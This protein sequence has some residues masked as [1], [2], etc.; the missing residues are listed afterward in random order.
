YRR[1]A[2]SWSKSR[3]WAA[4]T[5]AT[6]ASPQASCSTNCSTSAA[7]SDERRTPPQNRAQ[8]VA[9]LHLPLSRSV[10]EGAGGC[11]LAGG[12]FA[13]PPA[14]GGGGRGGVGHHFTDRPSEETRPRARATRTASVRLETPSFSKMWARWYSTVFGVMNSRSA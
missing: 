7:P 10:G 12:G 3:W 8:H 2:I 4:A 1:S 11:G 13:L 5:R 14:A 6:W 9:P